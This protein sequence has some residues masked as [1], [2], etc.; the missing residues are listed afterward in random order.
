MEIIRTD[1]V[2]N[3]ISYPLPIGVG[4]TAKC[5]RSKDGDVI[6]VYRDNSDARFLL[7]TDN[8]EEKLAMMKDI[9]NETFIGP[10][11]LLYVD[12]KLAGYIYDYVRANDLERI[13]KST[14]L[15]SVFG[16]F[17]IVL[18]N[19]KRIS[20]QNF[21]LRDVHGRNILF[22][23]NYHV[24]DLDRGVFEDYDPRTIYMKNSREVFATVIDQIYGLKPW[25]EGSYAY[26]NI[27]K[28]KYD[29]DV[30]INLVHDLCEDL[31]NA[32]DDEDPTI[33]KIRRIT[34]DR[35]F[36]NTYEVS[37]EI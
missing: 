7:K 10:R 27:N 35:K 25:H 19:L 36:I 17:D 4:T 18:D 34:L 15:S 20:N 2:K 14:R 9:S 11:K 6:K 22:N 31:R 5:Y 8:F 3:L 13:S 29:D 28:Y 33:R 37:D 32:C 26:V 24:I 16:H 23:G 21:I 30:D 1:N 12:N